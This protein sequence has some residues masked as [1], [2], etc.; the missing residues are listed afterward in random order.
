MKIIFISG[1]YRGANTWEVEQ[2]VRRAEALALEVWRLGHVAI[3]NDREGL[4]ARVERLK[5]QLK[6]LGKRIKKAEGQGALA[7]FYAKE[8]RTA[9]LKYGCHI[10]GCVGLHDYASECDC[11]FHGMRQRAL[12]GKE[13]DALSCPRCTPDTRT[14]CERC[15]AEVAQLRRD[16]G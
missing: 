11:G 6:A 12:A 13:K 4:R 10:G 16:Y 8:S 2:N 1:P 5:L 14:L 7:R 15:D 3:Y 9:F